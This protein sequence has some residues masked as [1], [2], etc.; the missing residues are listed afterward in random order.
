VYREIVQRIITFQSKGLLSFVSFIESIFFPIPTDVLLIP[1]CYSKPLEWRVL[2]FITTTTSVAGGAV[3]FFLGSF[4][5]TEVYPII[6]DLNYISEFNDVKNLFEIHG[7]LIILIASF[8]PLPYKLFTITAGF[9]S[10][11]FILFL[12]FS[13]IGRALRFYLV[14]YVTKE[15]GIV[16]LEY[17][18]RYFLYIALVIIS[19][20]VIFNLYN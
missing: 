15:H 7:A 11:D 3:G 5:F 8:T 16:I 12:I 14:A 2:A 9:L 20:Y 19:A 18:N 10:I 17:I 13:L 1:M 6:E 4:L